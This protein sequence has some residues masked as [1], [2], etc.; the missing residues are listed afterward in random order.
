MHG[1]I[2]Q[3]NKNL[4]FVPG[5]WHRALK[6]LGISL[7]EKVFCFPARQ[8]KWGLGAGHQQNQPRDQRLSTFSSYI[9][10][11]P[12]RGGAWDWIPSPVTNDL[13]HHTYKMIPPWKPL[14]GGVWGAS[15]LVNIL[16]VRNMMHSDSV[17]SGPSGSQIMCTASS[18]THKRPLQ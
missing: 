13:I 9:L 11:C 5:A 7:G 3:T 17:G 16:L 10:P 6:T 2:K 8:L 14:N 1:I 12:E 18:G 4:V 15:K